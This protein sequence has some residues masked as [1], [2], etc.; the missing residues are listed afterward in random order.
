MEPLKIIKVPLVRQS[1][2]YTCGIAAL[3]SVLAHYSLFYREDKLSKTLD[4]QPNQGTKNWEMVKFTKS[5]GL[6]AE[7]KTDLSIEDLIEQINL[8]NPVIVAIQAWTS[9]EEAPSW[10]DIWD[11]GHYVVTIGYDDQNLYFMDP[12]T[13]GNYTFIP[14][15]EFLERWHDVDQNHQQVIHLGIVISNPNNLKLN[16]P[17]EFLPI[18]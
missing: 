3:Q 11:H 9:D 5:L 8:G 6:H 1:T 12:S 13:L 18:K 14:K 2:T 16:D 10:L 17:D 7:S 15:N 4:A